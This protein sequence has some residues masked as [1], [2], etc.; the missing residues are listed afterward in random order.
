MLIAAVAIHGVL[1]LR[2]SSLQIYLGC[3]VL[4]LRQK[5]ADLLLTSDIATHIMSV[6]TELAA[7]SANVMSWKSSRHTGLLEKG[8]H[9]AL[10]TWQIMGLPFTI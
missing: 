6:Q 10:C 5:R 9:H 2:Q 1:R 4:L 7:D 3:S 8:V